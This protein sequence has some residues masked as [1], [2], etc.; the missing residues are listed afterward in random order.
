MAVKIILK[1]GKEIIINN[2][3]P[4]GMTFQQWAN[5]LAKNNT[6]WSIYSDAVLDVREVAYMYL[7]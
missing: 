6:G 5:Y 3:I 7:V 1:S 4:E 2:P